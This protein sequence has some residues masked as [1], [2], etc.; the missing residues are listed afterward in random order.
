MAEQFSYEPYGNVTAS[1]QGIGYPY[2]FAG[3]EQAD[4]TSGLYR[5]FARYYNPHLQRFLSEDPLG[6]TAGDTNFFSYAGDNPISGSDPSGEC[7]LVHP[8]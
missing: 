5:T 1:G 7:A 3:M 6:F 4:S 2:L 8:Q